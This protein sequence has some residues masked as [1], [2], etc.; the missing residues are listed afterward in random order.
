MPDRSEP[1]EEYYQLIPRGKDQVIG[2]IVR[3]AL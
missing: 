3:L 1:P 2:Q